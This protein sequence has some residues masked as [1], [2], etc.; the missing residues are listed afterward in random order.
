MFLLL[1]IKSIKKEM[2]SN[3]PVA[4]FLLHNV[5]EIWN[6]RD[7]RSVQAQSTPQVFSIQ[8][9]QYKHQ[10]NKHCKHDS[11]TFQDE[12]YREIVPKLLKG[13]GASHKCRAPEQVGLANSLQSEQT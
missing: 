13:H 2:Y 1:L 3:E 9:S 10:G 11:K 7:L 5:Y 6:L 4:P 12:L 8:L